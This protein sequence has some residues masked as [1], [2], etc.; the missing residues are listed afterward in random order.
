MAETSRGAADAAVD[1]RNVADRRALDDVVS[2]YRRTGRGARW[3]GRQPG[4][5]A[6]NAER[7]R[8]LTEM[9]ALAGLDVSGVVLDVGCG[10]GLAARSFTADAPDAS[11]VGVDLVRSSVAEAVRLG[12]PR[13][14][15]AHGAALPFRSGSVSLAVCW[16]MFAMVPP[17]S[18]A[19]VAADIVRV[20]R[21][22]GAAVV[23]ELRLPS[24]SN[25]G[26][27]RVSASE[28][29]RIFAGLDGEIR[30]LSLFPPVARRLGGA[31]DRLYPLL[32]SLPPLRSHLGAVLVKPER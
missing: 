23:Y 15:V 31:T 28:L 4:N 10:P 26:V 18:R 5:R 21:P 24:P 16:T 9:V 13:Y 17:D 8:V 29:R 12:G 14:A 19:A 6:I 32:A 20:L 1:D 25:R 27:W 11:I 3:N 7:H 22:G 2:E 30:S